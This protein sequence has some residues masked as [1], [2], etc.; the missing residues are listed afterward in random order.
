MRKFFSMTAMAAAMLMSAASFAAPSVYFVPADQGVSAGSAGSVAVWVGGTDVGAFDLNIHA[1]N[2]NLS[3]VDALYSAA[4]PLGA[5]PAD[6]DFSFTIS[7]QDIRVE[8]FSL[9][10]VLP[11]AQ[12]NPFLLFTLDFTAGASDGATKL[13]FTSLRDSTG[14]IS[15]QLGTNITNWAGQFQDQTT[16]GTA[17]VRVGAAASAAQGSD[18][19]YNG[20]GNPTP[21]PA[22]YAL[23][24]LGLLAAGLARRRTR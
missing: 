11:A 12:T 23:V 18:C 20:G 6:A 16:F 21:E 15:P 4:D 22:S 7:S 2:A 5:V 17:C 19:T 9:L 24:A 13:S 10:G 1:S 3:W 14:A 8:G